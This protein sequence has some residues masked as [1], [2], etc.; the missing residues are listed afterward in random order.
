MKQDQPFF[1]IIVPTYNRPRQLGDCL[2]AI[3]ALDYPRHRFEVVVVDD[4]SD[5]PLA[6]VVAAFHP[7]FRLTLFTQG[8][9]GPGAARNTGAAHAAGRFLAFTDDDCLPTGH[10]LK[11]LAARFAEAP[12]QAIAGRTINALPHNPFATASQLII[13]MVHAYY[14][15]DPHQARFSASNN[16]ALPT[17]MFHSLGGFDETF[18]TSE[19]RDFVDRWLHQ[20]HRLIYAPEVLVYHAHLL[21]WRGYCRMHFNYGRGAFRFHWARAR[22]GCAPFRPELKF[23]WHILSSLPRM[24]D[25]GH[26]KDAFSLALLLA[27]W[28][29]ANATGFIWE[30]NKDRTARRL[31]SGPGDNL[32]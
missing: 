15:A 9:A 31:T 30:N 26:K 28:Q 3:A 25:H 23:H 24:L 6:E 11:A 27:V 16:L 2:R 10:W 14:N 12:R 1:S 22:R 7:I 32:K 17:E 4:G 5:T 19:D 13:D 20:G 18:R 29:I 8:N 21:T